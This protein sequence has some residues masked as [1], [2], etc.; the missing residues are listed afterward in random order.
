MIYRESRETYGSPSIWDALVKQGHRIG[1]HRLARLM[2]QDGIRA[3][4]VKMRH[5]PNQSQHRFLVAENTLDRPVRIESQIRCGQETSPT[6]DLPRRRA[7][8]VLAPRDRLGNGAP[9]D[10]GSGRAGPHPGAVA[11]APPRTGS[12]TTRIAAVSIPPELPASAQCARHHCEHEPH[13]QLLGNACVESFFV[14]LKCGLVYHSQY[15][16]RDEARQNIVEYI[17]AFSNWLRRHSTLGYHSPAEF[18]A[19]STVT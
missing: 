1:E 11:P 17:E 19:R 3:K 16:T 15:R 5:A 9:S 8:S 14:T 18:E 7:R 13:R 4:T 10:R 2:C 6:S 12:C